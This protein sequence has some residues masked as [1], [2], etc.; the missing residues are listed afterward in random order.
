MDRIN[1]VLAATEGPTVLDLGAVQHDASAASNPDWLH[2]HLCERA[3][4]VIGVDI[5]ESEV[6]ELQAQGYDIRVDDVEA[7]EL[8]EQVDVVVAGEL[9]EHL[10]DLE[11][12]FESVRRSLRPG[13]KLVLT[14]PNPWGFHFLK[15][16]LFSGDVHRNPTH[17]M[18][19]D[20]EMLELHCERH[21]LVDVDIEYLEP[22]Q[23][24]I[25]RLAWRLGRRNVGSTNLKLTAREPRAE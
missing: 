17:T 9:I 16:A 19:L 14:T 22:P 1:R 4:E 24:G 11:G 5:A 13:G 8:D 2:G 20:E 12:F 7:L 18:W 23:R 15:Q 3:R 21:G 6:T 10:S 25:T